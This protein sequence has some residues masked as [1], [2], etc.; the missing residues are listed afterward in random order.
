MR[1]MIVAMLLVT[2]AWSAP[3]TATVI[4]VPSQ[5]PSIQ[6]AVNWSVSGDTLLVEPGVYTGTMNRHIEFSGKN[7]TVRSEA[8]PDVTVVDCQNLDYAFSIKQGEQEVIEGLTVRHGSNSDGGGIVV[9]SG[10][11]AII[12]SCSF[13]E[14]NATNGGALFCTGAGSQVVFD[15]CLFLGNAAV[16]PGVARVATA[17]VEFIDCEFIGNSSTSSSGVFFAEGSYFGSAQVTADRCLF[18][19][20]S[21]T[22]AAIFAQS[23]WYD[24]SFH[25]SE[26]VFEGN[27]SDEATI[28][29]GYAYSTFSQCLFDKNVAGTFVI[30]RL[31]G[32]GSWSIS[33]STFVENTAPA[34]VFDSCYGSSFSTT[35]VAFTVSGPVILGS[36][37]PPFSCCD[38]FGNE[39]GDWVGGVAGQL[40]VNGNI[41]QDPLFCGDAN[42]ES[43][44]SLHVNSPCAAAN[45]G[46]CGTI[47]RWDEGCSVTATEA[48]TWGYIKARY[49]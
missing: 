15:G 41:C 37:P 40:G 11:S 45:S 2:A 24:I 25:A 46:A 39:G 29:L 33:G 14:N 9:S 26:C 20:N 3:C 18:R 4:R 8:G 32:S 10:G 38:F 47:G 35:I 49:R 13:V 22:E 30:G 21:G 28:D 31:Y 44:Y 27:H 1:T 16:G 36:D 7:V 5:A 6:A 19:D 12:R 34:G 17:H 42:P 48:S 43:P 23:H